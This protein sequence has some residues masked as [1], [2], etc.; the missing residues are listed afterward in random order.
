MLLRLTKQ[1]SFEMAH[2]LPAYEGKCH[3]IHGHSYKLFVT[4]EGAPLQQQGAPTDGMV[5]D[6]HQLK[7]IVNR[8]IVE[9]FDHALVL[10]RKGQEPDDNTDSPTQLGGYAAKLILVDFQPTSEN[11]LLHFARLLNGQLPAG[12]RLHSL[13]LYET[14]TSCAELIL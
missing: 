4:V 10:P 14:E 7:E 12:T 11:L 3:N 8:H 2:A 5:L 9:Q 1:F 13:K 6:F